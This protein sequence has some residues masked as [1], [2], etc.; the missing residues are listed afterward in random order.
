VVYLLP[1]LFNKLNTIA[2]FIFFKF[3]YRGIG[4]KVLL[5]VLRENQT[6]AEAPAVRIEPGATVNPIADTQVN[7]AAAAKNAILS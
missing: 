2:T 4:Y 1:L 6:K 7:P 3:R 5:G